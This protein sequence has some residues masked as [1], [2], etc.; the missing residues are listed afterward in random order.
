MGRR[1]VRS[2]IHRKEK[3]EGAYLWEGEGSGSSI[4][5]QKKGEELYLWEGE[6]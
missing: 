6:G 2:L 4:Y 5:G 3:G 1:R